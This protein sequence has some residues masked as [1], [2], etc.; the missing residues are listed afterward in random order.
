MKLKL[1]VAALML[2][3]A[4]VGCTSEQAPLT[5]NGTGTTGGT[6]TGGNTGTGGTT[7]GGTTTTGGGTTGGQTIAPTATARS[8]TDLGNTPLNV[9]AAN[10]LLQGNSGA[11]VTVVSPTTKGGTVTVNADGSFTYTPAANF[12]GTDTFSYTLTNSAGSSSAIVTITIAG[13]GFYVNN[14]AAAPGQGTFAAPFPTLAQAVAAAGSQSG[15]Q[16]VVFQGDGTSNGYNTAVTL[17]ANQSLVGG[18]AT[19]QPTMTGP[20]NFSGNN[21]L[22]NIRIVGATG[23]AVNASG[24][25]NGTISG[26][27]FTNTTGNAVSLSNATGA[28]TLTNLTVQND[29]ISALDASGSSGSLTW[30]VTNS[31]FNN[32]TLGGVFANA[33]SSRVL[34]SNVNGCSFVKVGTPFSGVT[35]TTGTRISF[36][37][38]N[39]TDTKGGAFQGIFFL[40][41]GTSTLAGDILNN[42]ITG[43]ASDGIELQTGGNATTLVR[44][45]NNILTGNQAGSGF[46][47]TANFASSCLV[48]LSLQNNTSDTYN[49]QQVAPAVFRVEQLSLFATTSQNVGTVSTIGTIQDVAANSQGIP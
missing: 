21:T 16:L 24:T 12:T 29:T 34:T 40:N 2:G 20:I 48:A 31:T 44:L 10:G 35:N 27:P 36:T 1:T 38:S 22:Q 17:Q 43:H 45:N 19:A 49:F 15:A 13:V 28:F 37:Y 8:F 6:T 25:V 14:Q 46:A 39:N 23:N 4:L 32:V 9:T 26:V 41:E 42:T 5:D 33:T 18:N 47:A 11:T 7:T 30:S 3:T